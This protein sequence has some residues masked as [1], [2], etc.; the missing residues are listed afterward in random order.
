MTFSIR[1]KISYDP[2]IV[3]SAL[4]WIDRSTSAGAWSGKWLSVS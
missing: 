1:N 4:N 3:K 2:C